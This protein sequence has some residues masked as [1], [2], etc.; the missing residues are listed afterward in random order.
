MNNITFDTILNCKLVMLKILKFLQVP[1]MLRGVLTHNRSYNLLSFKLINKK[2]YNVFNKL[3]HLLNVVLINPTDH[4]INCHKSAKLY[5]I[6]PIN[7]N[8]IS[9][10]I[11]IKMVILSN[12]TLKLF[13]D[14]TTIKYLILKKCKVIDNYI[15][16]QINLRYLHMEHI[17]TFKG[18][19][20]KDM[21]KLKVLKI[22]LCRSFNNKYLLDLDL[23]NIYYYGQISIQN[24]KTII[25]SD[26]LEILTIF[27][28]KT[29]S[30]DESLKNMK[31]VGKNLKYLCLNGES[32]KLA[33]ENNFDEHYQ[34]S[35]F[36]HYY[37]RNYNCSYITSNIFS[38]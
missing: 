20:L 2:C 22:L 6:N 27:M 21:P 23:T 12:G 33:L 13:R 3:A 11:N 7:K 25:S 14:V 9:S 38:I 34:K 1:K 8:Y 18:D 31:Y 4:H 15:K 37:T 24:L 17:D 28:H 19:I 30:F 29:F 35:H 26:K 10:S 5:L 16:N 36:D 32:I